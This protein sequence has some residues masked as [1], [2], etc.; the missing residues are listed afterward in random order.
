M[1]IVK[2]LQVLRQ[3]GLLTPS[4]LLKLLGSIYRHGINLMALLRFSAHAYGEKIAIADDR[5]SLTYLQL[6]NMSTELADTLQQS[7]RIGSGRKVA[8]VSR[9][10]ASMVTAIYAVSAT[11][12]DLLL[13]NAEMSE[14]QLNAILERHNPHLL[15]ND[16]GG[17]ELSI[18]VRIDHTTERT[19]F[20]PKLRRVSSGKLVLL[21]AGTTGQA[22]EAPHRPSL[23]RYLK[24]F[25]DFLSRLRILDYS[26]AYIATPLYHGYG[27]AVLLLF[28]AAGKKAVLHPGFSAERACRLVREHQVEVATVVPLM[29]HKMLR[30]NADDLRSLRCIA[31]G[32]AELSPKLAQETRE[33]LGE[34]LY[35]LYGTSEAGLLLIATPE[36]LSS[37]PNTIG[38][39]VDG[40]QVR[41]LGEQNESKNVGDVGRLCVRSEGSMRAEMSEWIE[42]GDLGY[43][44]KSGRYFLRGR[45]DS[46]IVSGGENVYPYEV[47]QVLLLHPQVEDAAV[48]GVPDERFGQRLQA[49]VQRTPQTKPTEQELLDWLRPQLARYQLPRSIVF[50]ERLPYTA[51]GK[52]DKRKLSTT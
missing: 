6:Y 23:F 42:T 38:R 33:R 15:L 25:S 14:D 8:L 5:E 51:V 45:V 49:F 34:V 48:I 44:D 28:G 18:Q 17:G 37:T 46:M 31:S 27:L 3:L 1:S 52:R 19:P 32:G 16:E 29:L 43:M 47:E 11:G 24:P 41:V 13:L 22:K 30:T 26:T 50:V 2:L 21:T 10:Q 12:A 7:Y 20:Q 9:N 39:P 35:N 40:V 4:A 36:D